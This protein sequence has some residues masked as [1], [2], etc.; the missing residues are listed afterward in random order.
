MV[1][2]P[3]DEFGEEVGAAVAL[4]PGATATPDELRAFV[5]ER[6]AAYKYPRHVWLVDE[7]PKGP[8]GK[9]LR[10]EVQRPGQD[11]PQDPPARCQARPAAQDRQAAMSPLTARA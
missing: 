2:I 8:T 7:L 6:V 5:K 11:R 1:G 9:I 4:K 10:R 3:H